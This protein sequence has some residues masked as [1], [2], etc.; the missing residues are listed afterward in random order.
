MMIEYLKWDS[1]FFGFKIGKCREGVLNCSTENEFIDEFKR[2]GFDC[3]YL[4]VNL[5]D[6]A[7]GTVLKTHNL[8]MVDSQV[9]YE[10]SFN[11]WKTHFPAGSNA[12]SK[13]FT[14]SQIKQLRDLAQ[15][16]SRVSRFYKDP[17]FRSLAP[18]MYVKWLDN[19]L[20]DKRAGIKTV[21]LVSHS[22]SQIIGFVCFSLR[23][24]GGRIDLVK[25]KKDFYGQGI[26][27]NLLNRAVASMFE[28]GAENIIITVKTQA[29]NILANMLYGKAGF[30]L[31]ET[32]LIYHI[33]KEDIKS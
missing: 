10:L 27:S 24:G 22:D 4:F 33:W 17:M 32:K 1:D 30:L 11:Q 2:R 25:V 19:L 21:S 14:S 23:K 18:K 5:D 31:K 6:V 15:E 3:V 7:L 20:K 26:G 29:N 28:Y 12:F 9:T 8:R 16:L 13:K